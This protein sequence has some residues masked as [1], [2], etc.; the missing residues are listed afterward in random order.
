MPGAQA[1]RGGGRGCGAAGA[2]PTRIPA[3]RSLSDPRATALSESECAC[4][5]LRLGQSPAS[6]R[7]TRPQSRP[8]NALASPAPGT[9]CS[10]G[11]A[12]LCHGLA[13][14]SRR[15]NCGGHLRA[16]GESAHFTRPLLSRTNFGLRTAPSL[17]HPPRPTAN[18]AVG[19]TARAC[20]ATCTRVPGGGALAGWR[21]AAGPSR[22]AKT[23]A[24]KQAA[25]GLSNRSFRSPARGGYAHQRLTPGRDRGDS[26]ARARKRIG[27]R[28]E[29]AR[30]N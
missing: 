27:I 15:P 5:T 9:A 10:S 20:G 22:R 18:V 2:R 24:W 4:P 13:R 28:A 8:C 12:R 6:H 3:R 1:S 30:R 19:A 11:A 23:D 17:G 16:L 29:C 21:G 14:G 25:V 7:D 26:A